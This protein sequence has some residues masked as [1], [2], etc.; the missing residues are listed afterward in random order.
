[1]EGSETGSDSGARSEAE[2]AVGPKKTRWPWLAA[3]A[4]VFLVLISLGNWQVQRRAWKHDLVARVDARI[5]AVPVAAPPA[6]QWPQISRDSHEYQRVYLTG[7][8]LHQ[9]EALV[10]A[11]TALG[12]GFWVLTPLQASGGTTVW[13]NRGFVSP[14]ARNPSHRGAAAPEGEVRVEGLLRVTEPDGA[15]LRNNDPASNRWHSRD[16]HALTLSRGL[17]LEK[18]AP[19]FVDQEAAANRRSP[20]SADGLVQPKA[21]PVAGLTVVRFSDN[22]LVYALTWYGLALGLMAGLLWV[23]SRGRAWPSIAK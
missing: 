19:Y 6:A 1:M 5:H 11:T 2:V 15:F 10:Q 13:I 8:F 3:A 12:A 17:T 23:W 21:W 22:H 18:V 4:L 7:R 9:H 14:A 16:V 20:E